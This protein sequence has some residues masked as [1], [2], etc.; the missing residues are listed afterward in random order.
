[1]NDFIIGGKSIYTKEPIKDTITTDIVKKPV[2]DT[3][4]KTSIEEQNIDTNFKKYLQLRSRLNPYLNT[5]TSSTSLTTTSISTTSTNTSSN[6]INIYDENEIKQDIKERQTVLLYIIN[7]F[8]P[9]VLKLLLQ[10][11]KKFLLYLII[12]LKI[13]ETMIIPITLQINE[14]Y[15]YTNSKIS[16]LY[17][18]IFQ[19]LCKLIYIP[20]PGKG[21]LS[22][23]EFI[24]NAFPL[25]FVDVL[26]DAIHSICMLSHLALSEDSKV[27]SSSNYN[28]CV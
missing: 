3:V 2:Q 27:I 21:V 20:N 8:I 6:N 24:E 17:H 26:I 13:K 7:A 1:M 23:K 18:N 9:K 15:Q 14:C 25:E 10:N 19:Y 5:T 12:Y 28:I 4:T 16:Y 22:S 11:L